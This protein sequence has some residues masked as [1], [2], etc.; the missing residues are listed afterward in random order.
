MQTVPRKTDIIWPVSG[1]KNDF[2]IKL[3]SNLRHHESGASTYHY[4][5]YLFNVVD[6][7][8]IP[9]SKIEF[10]CNGYNGYTLTWHRV[11]SNSKS[12]NT[13]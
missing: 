11:F 8:R 6:H 13:M 4:A 10:L 3:D 12:H 5:T 2:Q 9:S 7:E 1:A